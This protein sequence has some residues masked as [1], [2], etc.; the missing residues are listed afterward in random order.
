MNFDTETNGK[1]GEYLTCTLRVFTWQMWWNALYLI[2]LQ[3]KWIIRDY[4][5][6]NWVHLVIKILNLENL[7]FY[8]CTL[9]N[10]NAKFL[11]MAYRRNSWVP[12][13]SNLI[14]ID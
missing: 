6:L 5:C 2:T 14:G 7:E 9:W 3:I 4:C 1:L 13:D 12:N 11:I 8:T 10:H